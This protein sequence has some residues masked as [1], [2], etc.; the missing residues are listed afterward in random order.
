MYSRIRAAW[1]SALGL[2][3]E[4]SSGLVHVPENA[5]YTINT[6]SENY[7]QQVNDILYRISYFAKVDTKP[8]GG[9]GYNRLLGYSSL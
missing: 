9:G 3:F 4:K 6:N 8:F 1:A 2:S 7:Q 5:V